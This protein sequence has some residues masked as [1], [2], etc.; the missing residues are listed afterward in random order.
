MCW[1]LIL[2]QLRAFWPL[3][4]PFTYLSFH[5]SCPFLNKCL[6]YKS[7]R[8]LRSS[9]H[10]HLG[11]FSQH[12]Y[13]QI[14]LCTYLI[15]VNRYVINM[16]SLGKVSQESLVISLVHAFLEN[17]A[18]YC[19][20]EAQHKVSYGHSSC[21]VVCLKGTFPGLTS[22]ELEVEFHLGEAMEIQTLNK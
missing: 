8:D 3:A 13:V 10:Y 11:S 16:Y 5:L 14:S 12:S 22:K 17:L 4:S 9:S 15:R 18:K 7:G 21:S 19:K 6:F 1:I 20:P 2:V